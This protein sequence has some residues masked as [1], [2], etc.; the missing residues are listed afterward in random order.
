MRIDSAVFLWES[1]EELFAGGSLISLAVFFC[2]AY[3][4]S[5]P[6]VVDRILF[7]KVYLLIGIWEGGAPV[8]NVSVYRTHG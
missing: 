1:S 6:S 4:G 2:F 3:W 5:I 7:P 8:E